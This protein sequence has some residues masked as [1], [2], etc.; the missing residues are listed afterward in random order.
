MYEPHKNRV[1]RDRQAF[2]DI[3]DLVGSSSAEQIW[4]M[5]C[6]ASGLV[7]HDIESAVRLMI[8]QGNTSFSKQFPQL[9]K[10]A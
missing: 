8:G 2:L 3:V 6:Y 7:Q 5:Y 1:V 9:R 10:H 4:A